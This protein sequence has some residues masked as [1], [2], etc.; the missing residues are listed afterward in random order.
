MSIISKYKALKICKELGDR[1]P[2]KSTINPSLLRRV[3]INDEFKLAY[4]RIQKNANSSVM[5]TMYALDTGE[6]TTLGTA[7]T[8]TQTLRD[9]NLGK[10]KAIQEYRFFTVIRNP[11][12]RV[13]SAFL[14]KFRQEKYQSQYTR[15]SLD[16]QGFTTFLHWLKDGGIFENTHWDLQQKQLLLPVEKYDRLI[17]FE[18]LKTELTEFLLESGVPADRIQI[19]QSIKLSDGRFHKTNADS[20]IESFYNKNNQD[21]VWSCYEADFMKLGYEK[22]LP[23]NS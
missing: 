1:C 14:D 19:P 11:Y 9:I 6:I 3:A 18:N 7:K 12:T 8:K 17:R 22:N 4:N 20:L 16:I 10:M 23:V 13:L 15:F 2:S 5:I 21:L